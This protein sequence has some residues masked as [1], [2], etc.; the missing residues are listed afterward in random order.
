MF[1]FVLFFFDIIVMSVIKEDE[2]EYRLHTILI[3]GT[4]NVLNG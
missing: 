1:F 3:V 2:Y 4:I